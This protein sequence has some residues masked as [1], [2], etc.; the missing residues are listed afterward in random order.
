MRLLPK[1]HSQKARH[2]CAFLDWTTLPGTNQAD[3]TSDRLPLR[4]KRPPLLLN[5]FSL[6]R[7]GLYLSSRLDLTVPFGAFE[8]IPALLSHVFFPQSISR[9]CLIQI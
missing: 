2:H 7:I 1:I 9:R 5:R 6:G 4:S 3:P 8:N